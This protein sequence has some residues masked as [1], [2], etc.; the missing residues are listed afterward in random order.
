MPADI[1]LGLLVG[2]LIGAGNALAS[3]LLFYRS[4]DRPTAIFFRNVLGGMLVR[5]AIVLVAVVLVIRLAPIDISYF[6]GT[7]FATSVVGLIIDIYFILKISNA[8][9]DTTS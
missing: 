7:L 1:L 5:L 6:I 8:P 3:L 2:G 4:R 9:T